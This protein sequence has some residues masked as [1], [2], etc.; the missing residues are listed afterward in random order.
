LQYRE[1]AFRAVYEVMQPIGI[2]E[3]VLKAW[4]FHKAGYVMAQ[5][6][7]NPSQQFAKQEVPLFANLP[8][9]HLDVVQK[10]FSPSSSTWG[11]CPASCLEQ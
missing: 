9:L 2:T 10:Q 11:D 3:R 4:I 1:L 6:L 5:N 8:Y 7:T